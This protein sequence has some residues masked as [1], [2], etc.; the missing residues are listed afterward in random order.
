[1]QMKVLE[2]DSWRRRKFHKNEES[3]IKMKMRK[4]LEDDKA[5]YEKVSWRW[6][7][8]MKMKKLLEDEEESLWKWKSF[9]KMKKVS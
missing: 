3:F 4:L 6:E 9:K 7:R 2:K 5:K 8:F 1:M